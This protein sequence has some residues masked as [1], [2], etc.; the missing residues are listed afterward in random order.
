MANIYLNAE[1]YTGESKWEECVTQCNDIINSGKYTLD[2]NFRSIFETV[3]EDSPERIFAVPFDMN[4]ATGLST[5]MYSWH[6]SLSKKVD[7]QATPWGSGSAMGITQFIDTYDPDDER[8]AHTWLMGPQFASDGVT[9]VI[10][11]YDQAGRPLVLTKD[12]PNGEYTGESEGYRMN[13]FEVAEGATSSLSNDFP[14]FR[15]AQV[16]LMKAEALLRTDQIGEASRL[17]TEVRL[18]HGFKSQPEKAVVTGSELQQNSKYQFG[19]I[20]NYQVVDPGDTSPVQFGRLLDELGWEFAWEGFRRRDMI[21]FGT[22]TTKSWLSHQP[23]GDHRAVFPIP[24]QAINSNPNL[25]QT[26]EY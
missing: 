11:T 19:Y 22:Y 18:A 17:V 7:M 14:F 12:L 20:E 3:N 24:Q 10:G 4:V 8:L 5:H 23:N 25:I 13:K 1:V 6:G 9:P 21:R 26:A 2:P 15:Y 16:L